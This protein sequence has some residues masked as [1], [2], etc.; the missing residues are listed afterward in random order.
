MRRTNSRPLAAFRTKVIRCDETPPPLDPRQRPV[1]RCR[2][3]A[4]WR[5]RRGRSWSRCPTGLPELL[6][7]LAERARRRAGR[8]Q[9]PAESPNSTGCCGPGRAPP[10]ALHGAR[11]PR[12]RRQP[13]DQAA[14]RRADR[15]PRRRA[16]PAAPDTARSGAS[17]CPAFW[18]EDK[19][20]TLALHYRA[21][22]EKA[23]EIQ[24]G[25]RP[26]A[27]R[28][29]GDALRLIAGKMVFELQPRHHGKD[30]RS[31]HSWPSR[32]FVAGCRYLSAT[33]RPTRTDSPR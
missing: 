9:R 14:R 23:A 16:R 29:H 15:K 13:G 10:P 7:R 17:G 4:C 11:T 20:R 25:D 30:G 2:R 28:E 31:P 6:T 22:P 19:G 32:R 24:V 1:P 18:L 33:I 21:A 12:R 8:D 3:H 26:A 27:A 5:S